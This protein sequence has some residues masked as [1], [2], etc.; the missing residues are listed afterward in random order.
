MHVLTRLEH[1]D[2]IGLD[3]SY[4]GEQARYVIFEATFILIKS[5]YVVKSFYPNAAGALSETQYPEELQFLP[6]DA[7]HLTAALKAVCMDQTHFW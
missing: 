5:L 1:L 2:L 3:L 4:Q 7:L 6:T